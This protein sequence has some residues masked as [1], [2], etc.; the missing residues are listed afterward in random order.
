MTVLEALEI[1]IESLAYSDMHYRLTATF[2]NQRANKDKWIGK[3]D[4]ATKAI[5][6]LEEVIK[7]C[8]HESK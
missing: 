5:D 8:K 1:A 4:K 6:V 2:Q 3:A 7:E